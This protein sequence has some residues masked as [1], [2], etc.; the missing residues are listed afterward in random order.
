MNKTIEGFQIDN[1]FG[2]GSEAL[3]VEGKRLAEARGIKTTQTTG[4]NIEQINETCKPDMGAGETL[5]SD[6]CRIRADGFIRGDGSEESGREEWYKFGEVGDDFGSNDRDIF[7]SVDSVSE[8]Q[9]VEYGSFRKSYFNYIMGQ[10]DYL[11]PILDD[12]IANKK[13]DARIS[14]YN[15]NQ[16]DIRKY[17]INQLKFFL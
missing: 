9:I 14:D 5:G 15:L 11:K 4:T 3:N 13:T 16:T 8:G 12:Q 2:F 7:G 1:N 6:N 10:Y 17:Q